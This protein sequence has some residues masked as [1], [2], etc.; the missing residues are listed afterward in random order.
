MFSDLLFVTELEQFD[1]FSLNTAFTALVFVA[2][3]V[4]NYVL[5]VPNLERAAVGLRNWI[6]PTRGQAAD[7]EFV[8]TTRN[9]ARFYVLWSMALGAWLNVAFLFDKQDVAWFITEA[10]SFWPDYGVVTLWFAAAIV[11]VFAFGLVA[12]TVSTLVT[13]GLLFGLVLAPV[14]ALIAVSS[15]VAGF[16][17]GIYLVALIPILALPTRG[18]IVT[19]MLRAPVFGTFALAELL[20]RPIGSHVH[21]DA[22]LHHDAF[23]V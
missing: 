18:A 12:L 17:A 3:A 23:P 4:A 5:S 2:L 20:F 7:Y 6:W 16:Y 22:W 21:N 19:I 14:L 15:F 9:H 11:A 10:F 1:T 13:H 8:R